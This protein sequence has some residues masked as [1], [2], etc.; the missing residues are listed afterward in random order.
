MELAN[1]HRLKVFV[2]VAERLSFSR[3][4]IRLGV[5]QPS[6]S[7][8]IK[9]LERT[10]GS[11]LFDHRKRNIT[12]TETGKNLY[13]YAR[14][15]LDT[16]QEAETAMNGLDGTV[17]GHVAIQASPFWEHS[18]SV[19]LVDF[20]LSHP[21]VS[22]TVT[23]GR[24]REIR[25]A[26]IENR[27]NLAFVTQDPRDAHLTV[28]PILEYE[29]A[30]VVMTPPG[31]PLTKLKTVELTRLEDF[32]FVSYPVRY[33]ATLLD[34]LARLGFRPKHVL[35]IE[36]LEAV[37]RAVEMGLGVC[38]GEELNPQTAPRADARMWDETANGRLVARRLLVPPLKTTYLAVRNKN[39][40]VSIAERAILDFVV[41]KFSD[42]IGVSGAIRN[43]RV[44]GS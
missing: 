38:V 33:G 35:E 2:E 11:A 12:L 29:T 37:V 16:V 1:V 8:H 19:L 43:N 10:V 13:R 18:L 32:P 21:G 40:A 34:H 6:V 23:F 22:L 42:T 15:I 4:A 27:T 24:P 17:A 25:E 30:V 41:A 39:R 5:T 20:Q 31:H 36:S 26:L 44:L 14:T 9:E 3:A 7:M 28:T